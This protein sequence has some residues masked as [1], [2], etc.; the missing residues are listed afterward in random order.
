MRLVSVITINFNHSNVTEALLDSVFNSDTYEPIE[1]IVVDNGSVINPVPGWRDKYPGVK[2]IRSE[3]NLGFSGGNNLGIKEAKGDYLFFVNNDTEVTEGLIGALAGT[4]DAR[5]E[6]G[7]VSPKIRYYEQPEVLQYA[8]YTPMNY[9]TAR[10]ACIG[11]FEMDKGQYDQLTGETGFG[12][13]AAMMLRREVIEKAGSMPEN[14]FLYYEEMDWCEQVKRAGYKIWVNMQALIY[15]KES[16]TVGGKSAMKEYFM[17]RNRILFVRRNCS[18][19]VQ[20]IFWPYFIF[21][22][23]V[24]NILGYIKNGQWDYIGVLLRAIVWN[25]THS[26]DSME[27]GYKVKNTA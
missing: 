16:I 7:M 4:L 14:Y 10:N 17:N 11:Q 26:K 21:V 24:R 1:V 6:V 9:Y 23:A 8:G 19:A 27:L 25:M 18:F 22:V 2:F 3:I 12:H 5:P 20:A 13:G 15:H